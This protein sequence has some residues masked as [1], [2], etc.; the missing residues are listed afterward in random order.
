MHQKAFVPNSVLSD[1][2]T[3]A[4]RAELERIVHHPLFGHS[5]RYPGMLRYVVERTL[6]GRAEE[7]KERTVGIEGL[8]RPV[9]YD[10]AQD[11]V[12]RTTATELRRR[13]AEYYQ[14]VGESQV[15][16]QIPVGSYVPHFGFP[17]LGESQPPPTSADAK[18]DQPPRAFLGARVGTDHIG[19]IV[20]LV[21]T[22]LGVVAISV[23]FYVVRA[24]PVRPL[25]RLWAPVL[26]GGGTV[27]VY[28]GRAAGTAPNSPPSLV[29][30]NAATVTSS[31]A[32]VLNRLGKSYEVRPAESLTFADLRA[33]PVISVGGLNNQWTLALTRGLRFQF[34][35]T[36]NRALIVDTVEQRVAWERQIDATKTPATVVEDYAIVARIRDAASGQ[37]VL[38]LGGIGHDGT[39]AAGEFVTSTEHLQK[40]AET[41]PA[42][43]ENKNIEIVLATRIQDGI[44]G[45]PRIVAVHVWD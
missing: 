27:G 17:G 25:D 6:E 39:S 16:I 31:L 8:G 42:G 14:D 43:W 23:W 35:R 10:P 38:V 3:A 20:T 13:L 19:R 41:A 30:M 24:A 2:A 28:V 22:A 5:K 34:Q 15:C 1:D 26:S 44:T 18:P 4:V 32:G 33:R 29:T 21:A 9:S 7:L 40:L 12:V 36:G 45:P 37:H 11:P